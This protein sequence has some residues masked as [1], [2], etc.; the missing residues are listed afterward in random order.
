MTEIYPFVANGPYDFY[1]VDI[2]GSIKYTSPVPKNNE[3]LDRHPSFSTTCDIKVH[4]NAS[5]STPT[6]V[7]SRC[8]FLPLEM[9]E[10]Q[11]TRGLLPSLVTRHNPVP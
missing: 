10:A 4:D 5:A 9:N 6:S 7:T 2:K 8:H 3:R 1:S 11:Q